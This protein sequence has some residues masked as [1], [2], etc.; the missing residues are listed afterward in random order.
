MKIL[1]RNIQVAACLLLMNPTYTTADIMVQTHWRMGEDLTNGFGTDSVGSLDLSNTNAGGTRLPSPFTTGLADDVP[2][3]TTAIDLRADSGRAGFFGGDLGSVL[4]A[5]NWGVEMWVRTASTSQ[6]IDIF[7]DGDVVSGNLKFS[8]ING[9]WAASYDSLAW[10]GAA[11]GSGQTAS[12]ELWTHLAVVNESGTSSLYIDG[13]AQAGT[14]TADVVWNDGIH[15]GVLSGGATGWEGDLDE[16]RLFTF[17][18]GEFDA[19]S[20]FLIIPEP[21]SIMLCGLAVLLS[22]FLRRRA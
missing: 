15:L 2:G 10:I 20:D 21:S 19:S 4:T 1:Y 18:P 6:N 16:V 13:V 11:N 22:L 8:Q 5:D 14:T 3:S 9:L 17:N 7:S 12:A